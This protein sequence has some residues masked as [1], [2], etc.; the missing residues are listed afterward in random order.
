MDKTQRN[1]I[2]LKKFIED[3]MA[4]NNHDNSWLGAQDEI[5]EKMIELEEKSKTKVFGL[6]ISRDST[7]SEL[8][9]KMAKLN[10]NIDTF[11]K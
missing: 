6:R 10:A 3:E 11:L 2:E 7:P 9:N 5:L 1:W 8:K 4:K